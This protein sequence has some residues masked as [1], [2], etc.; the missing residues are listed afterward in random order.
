MSV[1]F[2]FA[3][4]LF[5]YVKARLV[6]EASLLPQSSVVLLLDGRGAFPSSLAG[7]LFSDFGHLVCDPATDAVFVSANDTL[8]SFDVNPRLPEESRWYVYLTP[9]AVTGEE[10]YTFFCDPTFSQPKGSTVSSI[11]QSPANR[12]A[13]AAETRYRFSVEFLGAERVVP[14]GTLARMYSFCTN[15]K[16]ATHCFTIQDDGSIILNPATTPRATNQMFVMDMQ[17]ILALPDVATSEALDKAVDKEEIKGQ[18]ALNGA[19]AGVGGIGK[20]GPYRLRLAVEAV[21]SAI[22]SPP[23]ELTSVNVHGK[24]A[25]TKPRKTP[26]FLV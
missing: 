26:C 17:P 20:E 22:L 12:A 14:Y 18:G 1:V 4:L 13:P 9:D 10:L 2:T 21:R 25:L 24:P 16:G 5:T 19:G 8:V 6:A 23:Y 3:M 7:P 15:L 11:M